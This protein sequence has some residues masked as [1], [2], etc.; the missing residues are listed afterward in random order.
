M[1]LGRAVLAFVY[2]AGLGRAVCAQTLP[3]EPIVVAGGR[4]TISGDVSASFA[5]EDP[6]FYNYTDYEHSALRM[7]R[8]DVS[9]IVNAGRHLA[10]LGEIR[11]ENAD[12]P[13]PYALYLR[14]RPWTDRAFDIQIGRVPPTFG[15]FARRTYAS[16][17]PLIGYPL[18][19]QYL[20]ALRPDSLPANADEL[21]RMRGR[22]WLSNFSLGELAPDRGVPLASVLRW[23]TGV[24][25]HANNAVMSATAAVTAGTIANPLF[26]DDNRGKQFAGRLALTP[27]AGLVVGAS[28]SRGPFVSAT[29]ARGA[30]GD[31]H[32]GEFTQ[33]A[34]GADVEF[35]RGYYLLRAEAIASRWSLPIVRWPFLPQTL[36]AYSGSIEG[37]YKLGPGLYVAGRAD[38]LGFSTITGSTSTATWDAPVTRVEVGGGYSIQRNLLFKLSYQHNTRDTARSGRLNLAAAQLV[39]WF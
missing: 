13:R 19:Y 26:K 18:A 33:T 28:A 24:Q 8:V 10:V 21:L 39:F 31:G 7:L 35:S 2:A 5:P 36:A 9:A 4:L 17:N 14:V 20:T 12:Y 6:G 1:K 22:G 29:A 3:D 37:R 11:A 25:V 38:H 27:I 30:V 34:W 23:D 32:D 16:D 15:A